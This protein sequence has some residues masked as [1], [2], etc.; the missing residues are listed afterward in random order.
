MSE[1][2]YI[3]FVTGPESRHLSAKLFPDAA[4]IRLAPERAPNLAKASLTSKLWLDPG[5]DG[6]DDFQ[7]RLKQGESSWLTFIRACKNY[8]KI[9]DPGYQASPEASEVQDFAKALLDKCYHLRPLWITVPQLP[10]RDSRRN[11]INRLLAQATGRWRSGSDFSGKLILPLIFTHQGQ[12]NGK[13]SRNPRV[14]QAARCYYESQADGFWVVDQSLADDSGSVSLRSTRLASV[15]LLHEELNQRIASKIRIA[16]PYWA[17]NLVLWAKGLIEHPA[18]G[19]GSGYQFFLAGGQQS[20]PKVKVALPSLRRR[21][22]AGPS[23]KIWLDEVLRKLSQSH[24]AYTEFN[25]IRRRFAGFNQN[26]A[27]EQVASFYKKWIDLIAS[28][29]KTGRSMALF[30]DLSSAYALGKFLPDLN[31]AEGPARRPESI[32]EPLMMSCL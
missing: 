15:I 23:L 22:V 27:R 9:G 24:P 4:I 31:G 1:P 5:I 7:N 26:T 32:V 29:P 3:P 6:M 18:I 14:E 30:Q 2:D 19:M 25:D 10:F 12:L 11:K 16:G 8:E 13:V 17:L 28:A 21:V 20:Q